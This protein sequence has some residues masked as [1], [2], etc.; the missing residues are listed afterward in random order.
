MPNFNHTTLVGHLCRDWE[1]RH[2]GSNTA[3]ASNAIAVSRRWTKDGQQHE[4]TSFFDIEAWTKAAETLN[5]YTQK[6][7]CI[8][9]AGRLV[10]DRWEDKE[11]QKRSR[12]KVVIETFQFIDSKPR[13]DGQGQQDDGWAERAGAE[14]QK[15]RDQRRQQEAQAETTG[16]GTGGIEPEDIPFHWNCE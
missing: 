11:G 4:E 10:Q 1:L 16:A 8:L 2:T 9:I 3:V 6:G 5:Q 7:S 12:I 14:A 15:H 13:Q